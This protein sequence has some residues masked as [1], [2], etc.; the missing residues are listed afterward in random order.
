[1]LT[2]IRKWLHSG[3][4]EAGCRRFLVLPVHSFKFS[5]GK[6]HRR[7]PLSLSSAA[8]NKKGTGSEQ[9]T[10]RTSENDG[11][12][13]PVPFLFMGFGIVLLAVLAFNSN[14]LAATP[15]DIY[16]DMESGNAGDLLTPPL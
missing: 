5:G 2:P 12:E 8:K 14:V 10:S 16:Q 15:V 6:A 9:I 3:T 13:V 11:S 4:V 7:S 1:M